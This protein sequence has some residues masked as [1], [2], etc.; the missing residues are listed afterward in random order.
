MPGSSAGAAPP[1]TGTAKL[2]NDPTKAAKA[3]QEGVVNAQ[4]NAEGE[5]TVRSIE[6]G[7]H[8][9]QATRSAQAAALEA[10]KAE[11]NALDDAALPAARREQVRRYFTELRKRFEK[12]N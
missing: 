10:I 5:S 2:G 9:E 7:V 1:G 12:E 11:E 4:R 6:G 3:G 8:T